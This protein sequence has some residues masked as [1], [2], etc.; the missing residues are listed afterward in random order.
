MSW[1]HPGLLG[2]MVVAQVSRPLAL[3]E[4]SHAAGPVFLVLTSTTCGETNMCISYLVP[5]RQETGV[6]SLAQA[7]RLNTDN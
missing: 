6:K 1:L 3:G 4:A 7:A 2:D 5:S